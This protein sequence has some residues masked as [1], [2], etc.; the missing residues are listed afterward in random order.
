MRSTGARALAFSPDGRLLLSDGAR[1]KDLWDVASGRKIRPPKSRRMSGFDPMSMMA[2][3]EINIGGLGVAFSPD[4]RL[5]ARGHGEV[6][7]VW[8]VASGQDRFE[9]VGHSAAVKSLQF[10]PD[11][12]SLISGGSDGAVRLW[13]LQSGKEQAALIAL[14]H[15]DF[16]TVLP[17]QY[18]RASKSRIKGVSFRVKEQ[19]YPFEQFDLR[20]NRPD[21]VMARLGM[22]SPDVVQ[23]YQLAYARRLKKMGMKEQMLGKEFHLPEL[24]LLTT[25]VPVSVGA[26][27]LMLR[28]KAMDSKYALDRLNVFVND[29]PV[30]GTAGLSLVN[31]RLQAHEQDIE[32]PWCRAATRSRF[33]CSINRAWNH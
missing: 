17:D 22:V 31:K 24:D 30:Y 10:S 12:R 14:G 11:G 26:P 25:D 8:D 7:K 21:I 13:N 2:N 9:L 3:M 28:V 27:S 20:F 32:V 29:V 33:P 16:V 6:I 4:G 18:Y 1:G 15:E 19:L 23:S 5:A